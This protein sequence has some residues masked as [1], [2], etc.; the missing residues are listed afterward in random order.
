MVIKNLVLSGGGPNGLSQ[1]GAIKNLSQDTIDIND[2]E[3]I[4]ATSI[5]TVLSILLAIKIDMVDIEEYLIKKNWSKSFLH[6]TNEIL[7]LDNEKGLISHNFIKEILECFYNS[8]DIDININFKDL[9]EISKKNLHFYSIKLNDYTLTEFSYKTTPDMPVILA[10]IASCSLPPIFGPVLYNNEYY[11]DGGFLNNYPINSCLNS[12]K[13]KHEEILGIRVRGKQAFEY[14]N[15]EKDNFANYLCKITG[16]LIGKNMTDDFQIDISNNL[17]ID[18][19]FETTNIKLWD[20]FA[21]DIEF[22]KKLI[23]NGYKLA[24]EFKEKIQQTS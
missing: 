9:Y 8:K 19:E 21:N 7:Y 24:D 10:C 16:D 22:R 11:I 1:F 12:T 5:G 20:S 6:N 15:I 3:N 17:V 4:Y 14:N 18:T 13:C 2:I 23:T